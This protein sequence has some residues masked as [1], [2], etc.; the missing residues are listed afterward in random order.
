MTSRWDYKFFHP[1]EPVSMLDANAFQLRNGNAS[2]LMGDLMLRPDHFLCVVRRIERLARDA[3]DGEKGESMYDYEV[4]V[5]SAQGKDALKHYLG[6]FMAQEIATIT[7]QY[8]VIPEHV[9]RH[10]QK[11]KVI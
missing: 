10:L 6:S 2:Q 5:F 7:Y 3:P 11:N 9:T 1:Q 4:V 8:W